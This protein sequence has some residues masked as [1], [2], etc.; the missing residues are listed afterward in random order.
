MK[1]KQVLTSLAIVAALGLIAVM[2]A[3][4]F[5][6]GGAATT[7]NN[8]TTITSALQEEETISTMT[9][10]TTTNNFSNAVL[11]SPFS[12]GEGIEASVNQ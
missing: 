11:G 2:A 1:N 3:V 4:P 10:T 5:E 12:F 8:Q 9:T 7:E 6:I